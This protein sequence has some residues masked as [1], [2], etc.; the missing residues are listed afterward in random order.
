MPAGALWQI[1]YNDDLDHRIQARA[2]RQRFAQDRNVLTATTRR[3]EGAFLLEVQLIDDADTTFDE[4]LHRIYERQPYTQQEDIFAVRYMG[5]FSD[6]PDPTPPRAIDDQVRNS[7]ISQYVNTSAGRRALAQ[8]MIA[9]IRTTR[10]YSSIGRRAFIVEE[11]P[12]GALPIY[13]KDLVSNFDMPSW[14]DEGTWVKNGDDYAIIV[15]TERKETEWPYKPAMVT[16]QVWRD[17][18]PPKTLDAETFCKYWLPSEIPKEPRTRFERILM[19][20]D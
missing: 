8:S 11:L 2:D 1:Q 12:E 18:G 20:D 3:S 4:N 15:S 9:P 14:V 5:R 16:Y 17:S 7:I 19:D 6:P 13:D 10:D